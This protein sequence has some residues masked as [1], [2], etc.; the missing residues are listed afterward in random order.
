MTLMT[1]QT[2]ALDA[3][4]LV[5]SGRGKL[6][7]SLDR[8]IHRVA[9]VIAG[10]VRH[11]EANMVPVAICAAIMF[12]AYWFVWK[13]LFPQPYENIWIR[14]FG[15][16]LCLVIAAK[17]RWPRRF[18]RYLPVVWLGT[19]F[20]S[21]PFFF[22]FMLL[23][24]DNS[25]VWLMS[26]MAGLFL[27][28]L[29]LDWISVFVLFIAGSVLAWRVHL[30]VSPDVAAV[31][32][33]LEYVPIFLFALTAGT[34]FSYKAAGLRQAKERARLELGMLL[35]KEMQSPLVSIRTNVASLSRFLPSLVRAYP[36]NPREPGAPDAVARQL[37]A[38]ERVPARIDEAVEQMDG[39]I[40]TLMTEGGD[41]GTAR[42]RASS[43]LRCLDDATARL[44]F[45]TELDRARIIVDRQYDFL[46]HGSPVLMVHA[47]ARVLDSAL[48]E[49]Y[50]ETGAELDVRLG[51]V[52]G[53]NYL[54]LTDSS[55]GLRG[56]A[57]RLLASLSG[58]DRDFSSRPDL[59]LA[60]LVL[61]RIGGSVTRTFAFGRSSETVLWFAQPGG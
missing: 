27:V 4:E 19:V 25:T 61:E 43:M 17:D 23:Q 51:Q 30:I 7:A 26:T 33:Y 41:A 34:I 3:D 39:I 57:A 12:P 55:A 58:N 2:T 52:G 53:W 32:V 45:A 21:G 48:S 15:S 9:A 8:A 6:A 54:R 16:V 13:Y 37:G 29:L 44:T 59:A 40:E 5:P 24:N 36:E 47:L 20:Y 46:F 11:V 56:T 10:G 18:R 38:L 60:N 22:T 28:V 14:V 49:I 1:E 42:Q 35:A 50:S 31:G